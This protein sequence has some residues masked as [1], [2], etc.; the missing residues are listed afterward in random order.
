MTRRRVVDPGRPDYCGKC[1]ARMQEQERGGTV[2]PVC[3]RCGWVYY[4]RNATGAALLLERDGRILLARR[5]HQPYKDWWAIPAGF[6]EYGDSAEETVLREAEEEIG[7]PVRIV[8]LFG[9]W[10]GAD[11]PRDVAHLVVYRVEGEG[12][13]RPGDDV[14]EVRFFGRDELPERIAF[15]AQRQAIREW[16]RRGGGV[17]D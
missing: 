3:P 7:I 4:A 11:D 9:V 12:E 10:F 2:R 13:P 5:A 17:V 15:E 16:A 1:A 14:A 6:V 8:G